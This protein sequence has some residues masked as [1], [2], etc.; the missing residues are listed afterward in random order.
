MAVR[1]TRKSRKHN[2]HRRTQKRRVS[3]KNRG[4]AKSIAKRRKRT[5]RRKRGGNTEYK[6]KINALRKMYP[7][8]SE[9]ELVTKKDGSDKLFIS[10]SLDYL[11]KIAD[12]PYP[13]ATPPPE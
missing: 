3:R 13:V 6:H 12:S 8:V 10:Y 4:K 7:N 11:N 2:R 9:E 1:K 5:I